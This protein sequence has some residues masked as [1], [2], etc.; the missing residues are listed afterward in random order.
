MAEN[1]TDKK[2]SDDSF[3]H[4]VEEELVT[5]KP[6]LIIAGLLL[7]VVGAAAITSIGIFDGDSSDEVVSSNICSSSTYQK[8]AKLYAQGKN[9]KL[10]KLAQQIESEGDFETDASC[11]MV[12]TV[13]YLN[14][15]DLAK[16]K[17]YKDQLSQVYSSEVGYDSSVGPDLAEKIPDEINKSIEFYESP[18]V[19]SPYLDA[20]GNTEQEPSDE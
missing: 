19:E 10:L 12:M 4:H 16:A 9:N 8:A 3:V 13:G 1:K 7:L 2:T 17:S 11:L 18:S 20:A 5:H 15:G 14:S 6:Q